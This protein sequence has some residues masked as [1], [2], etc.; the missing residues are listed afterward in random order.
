MSL[1]AAVLS[2]FGFSVLFMS[3]VVGFTLWKDPYCNNCEEIDVNRKSVNSYYDVAQIM[4]LNPDAEVIIV[5]TSRG[6]GFSPYWLSKVLNKKVLNLA[7]AGSG[8]EA[9]IAFIELAKKMLPLKLVIW[10]ADYF[11]ILGDNQDTEL[12]AMKLYN[13]EKTWSFS[14]FRHKALLT[15]DHSN[16]EAALSISGKPFNAEI[17]KLGAGSDLTDDCFQDSFVGGSTEDVL[18]KEIH[19]MYFNYTQQVFKPHESQWKK[20]LMIRYLSKEIGVE[21]IVTF[22]PYHPDFLEK[23]KQEYP[24]I[25]AGHVN[26]ISD[27]QKA[28]GHV[29]NFSEGLPQDD[30]SPKYWRDGTHFTCYTSYL[31]LKS[32]IS[33]YRAK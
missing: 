14:N 22:V 13:S 2:F 17:F 26:W 16:F 9:R 6:Q 18:K 27:L 12:H 15:I 24:E 11:E 3:A 10:Q 19:L 31:I 29:R 7:V 1:K 32:L 33:E 21:S 4:K 28:T 8:V 23:L 5:G 20:D 30:G 25:L